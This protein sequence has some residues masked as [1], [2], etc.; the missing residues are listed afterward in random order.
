MTY[1]KA[2]VLTATSPS[3]V[4]SVFDNRISFGLGKLTPV[5]CIDE[6]YAKELVKTHYICVSFLHLLQFPKILKKRPDF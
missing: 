1:S 3:Y 4:Q 2:A 6:V 5:I